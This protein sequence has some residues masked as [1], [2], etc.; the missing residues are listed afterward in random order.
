MEESIFDAAAQDLFTSLD[1]FWPT[2]PTWDVPEANL[3]VH[4]HAAARAKG[5]RTYREVPLEVAGERGKRL[6]ML[7]IPIA[8]DQPAVWI[9]A[10]RIWAN[11]QADDILSDIQ[12]LTA[13]TTQLGQHLPDSLQNRSTTAVFV[14]L[15]HRCEV[16]EWWV[17]PQKP[18]PF[19]GAVWD[20][21]LPAAISTGHCQVFSHSGGLPRPSFVLTAS[22]QR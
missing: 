17:A 10:K 5:S 12:R 19:S 3:L 7:I 13:P 15:T 4:L 11:K 6:D 1:H 2:R 16:A 20:G 9:E 18:A 8:E 14:A 21:A 22:W